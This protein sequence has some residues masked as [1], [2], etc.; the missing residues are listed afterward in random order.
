VVKSTKRNRAASQLTGSCRHVRSLDPILL[1]C[2]IID[3]AISVFWRPPSTGESSH[4][5]GHSA[6]RPLLDASSGGESDHLRHPSVGV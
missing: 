5:P 2:L 4:S 3:L 1:H 6:T